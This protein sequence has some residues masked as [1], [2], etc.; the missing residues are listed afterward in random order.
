MGLR[1]ASRKPELPTVV[2]SNMTDSMS[3]LACTQAAN[4]SGDLDQLSVEGGDND[5]A[6]QAA[7]QAAAALGQLAAAL[8]S[9]RKSASASDAGSMGSRCVAQIIFSKI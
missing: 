5:I 9:V 3:R 6:A 2:Y 7:A 8:S 1:L 4:R